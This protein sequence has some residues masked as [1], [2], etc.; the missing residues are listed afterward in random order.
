MDG[1][2]RIVITDQWS[3]SGIWRKNESMKR[4]PI[5]NALYRDIF[6][7][8]HVP[9]KPGESTIECTLKEFEA[10][11]DHALGIDVIFN[12]E[13]GQT[14]TL[15]EKFLYRGFYTVTVEYMQ[16]WQKETPGD[17]FNLKAQYYFTGEFGN[18]SNLNFDEWILLD[19]PVVMRATSQGRINWGVRENERDGA[20]ASFKWCYM[21]DFPNDCIVACSH[22]IAE[23]HKAIEAIIESDEYRQAC[24]L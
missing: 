20:C 7:G 24:F 4:W 1:I 11:Y 5:A 14:A 10:G 17:W 23:S 13:N 3:G 9:L 21:H 16:D 22:K 15:Q 18:R 19:W 2:T 8:I 6:K 12:F